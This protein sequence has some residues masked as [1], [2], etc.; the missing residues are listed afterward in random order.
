MPFQDQL[1]GKC[2]LP[3]VK[4]RV[5]PKTINDVILIL[6]FFISFSLKRRRFKEKKST[7]DPLLHFVLFVS[8]NCFLSLSHSPSFY[9]SVSLP[10]RFSLVKTKS[11]TTPNCSLSLHFLFVS[12]QPEIA[13][14]KLV[15]KAYEN[16][17]R[18]AF[19]ERNE[20]LFILQR[21]RCMCACENPMT[22]CW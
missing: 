20:V 2:Y 14:I 3:Q 19:A 6:F 21:R 11:T 7:T 4:S 16:E 9:F 13:V 22:R 10:L 18:S 12:Q 15:I 17:L 5:T 1:L 8:T